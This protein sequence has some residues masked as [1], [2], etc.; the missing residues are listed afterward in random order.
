M[1]FIVLI[2]II[3]TFIGVLNLV[4]SAHNSRGQE[5]SVLYFSGFTRGKILLLEL[6]ELVA[7]ILLAIILAIPAGYAFSAIFDL[8]LNSFGADFLH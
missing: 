8:S 6:C 7:V 3:T 2:A 4:M 1:E 5:F